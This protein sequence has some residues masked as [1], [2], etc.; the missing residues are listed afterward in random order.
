MQL[1]AVNIVET[2]WGYH[3]SSCE[4]EEILKIGNTAQ[5]SS[6]KFQVEKRFCY[7]QILNSLV[8]LFQNE[9]SCKSVHTKMD[10]I[11]M[12]MNL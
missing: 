1:P 6:N 11:C 9:S 10:F 7:R 12:K 3:A 2:S 4:F 8:P 5:S